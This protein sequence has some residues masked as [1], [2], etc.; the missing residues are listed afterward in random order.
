MA[1]DPPSSYKAVEFYPNLCQRAYDDNDTDYLLSRLALSL[2]NK[3]WVLQEG[4]LTRKY[5]QPEKGTS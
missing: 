2:G 5:G 1:Q 4:R 3:I